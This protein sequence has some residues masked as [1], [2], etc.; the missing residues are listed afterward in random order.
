MSQSAKVGFASQYDPPV[1]NS[2]LGITFLNLRYS[3]AS[4]ILFTASANQLVRE[5]HQAANRTWVQTY[6]GAGLY[7][8]TATMLQC[9]KLKSDEIH[10][11]KKGAI[12]DCALFMFIG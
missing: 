1:G 5:D 12:L 2:T 11:S 4:K 9:A 7:R 6:D 8:V 10:L 3:C